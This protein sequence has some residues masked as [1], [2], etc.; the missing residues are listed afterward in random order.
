MNSAD[1]NAA[2]GRDYAQAVVRACDILKSFRHEGEVLVLSDVTNRT[3]LSKTTAFRLLRSLMEGGLVERVR[4]GEYR[5]LFRPLASR[6][7]RLGFAA[8]TDSEFSRE[9]SEGLQRAAAAKENIHLIV[10]NNRYSARE[11]LRNAELLIRER[12]DL[13]IEFQTYQRIAPVI[14][15]KF[16]EANIP[17][18]AIEVPHPGATYF[19]ANNYQAG[20]MGGRALGRWARE[21]WPGGPEQ[22]LLLELPIAGPLPGLRITGIVDGM[23]SELPSI[24]KT[25]AVHLDGKGDFER[26]LGVVRR[27]LRQAKPKR[28][29]VGAVNDMCALAALRAFEEAGFDHF[30]AVVGQNGTPEAR[31]ELRRPGTRLVGSVGYFPERYGDGLIPLAMGILQKKP[32]PSAVFVKHRLLTPDNVNLIYPLDYKATT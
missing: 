30:C 9:V 17:L 28:T 4:K 10:L 15:S 20:L 13:A 3:G 1:Q 8:Q 24:D 25:P 19:G 12:V 26:I 22:V 21:N 27:F 14:A 32:T 2:R 18:I 29:L 5:C 31:K 7:L 16:L 11:A 23:R 6:S